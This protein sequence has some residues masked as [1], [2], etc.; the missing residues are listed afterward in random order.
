MKAVTPGNCSSHN[1]NIL[2][3]TDKTNAY[4]KEHTL[5]LHRSYKSGENIKLSI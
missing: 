1:F 4:S 5:N 2:Q 3:L